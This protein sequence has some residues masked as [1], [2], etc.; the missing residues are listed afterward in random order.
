MRAPRSMNEWLNWLFTAIAAVALV[1]LVLATRVDAATVSG[2]VTHATKYEDGTDLGAN[3][4]QTRVEVGTCTTAGAFS[5]KEG[6]ALVVPPSTAWSVTVARSWGDFCA[7]A[8]TETVSGLLSSY[9][10]T[11]KVT[12]VEP[13]PSPPILTVATVAFE[14]RFDKFGGAYLARNV[15]T[16]ELGVECG[17]LPLVGNAFYPIPAEEIDFDKRPKVGARFVAQCA[18]AA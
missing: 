2:T 1:Y 4:K 15:G 6:E 7:R 10:G 9:T 17:P 14:V 12:K 11:V 13:K 8:L 3:L 5:T 16:V 18:P